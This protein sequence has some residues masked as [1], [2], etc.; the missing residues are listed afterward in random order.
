MINGKQH[1]I[2]HSMN[3]KYVDL[4][5]WHMLHDTTLTNGFVQNFCSVIFT[6]C[7]HIYG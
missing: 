5:I 1:G 2:W 6:G 3:A 7:E 4:G